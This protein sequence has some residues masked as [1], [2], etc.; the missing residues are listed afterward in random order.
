MCTHQ[1]GDISVLGQTPAQLFQGHM[2]YLFLALMKHYCELTPQKLL[3]VLFTHGQVGEE[4]FVD[5]TY[6]RMHR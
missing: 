6:P 5:I 2:Q 1:S 3:Y 4:Y